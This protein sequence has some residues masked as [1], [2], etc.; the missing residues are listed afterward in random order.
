MRYLVHHGIKGQKWGVRRYR[1]EDGTLTEEGRKRYS[2][3]YR[4]RATN[5][6][7]DD[8][9]QIVST[10]SNKER[11]FLNMDGPEYLTS[12]E[13]EFVVKR[14]I[15]RE[16]DKPVA[17]L[18]LIRNDN[19]DLE[20]AL[21]TDKNHR[22]SGHASELTKKAMQWSDK[23][24]RIIW[25]THNNNTASSNIATK[26]GFAQVETGTRNTY[27]KVKKPKDFIDS[28]GGS[29][30]GKD[31]V[32]VSG[33]VSYDK[34]L[35]GMIRKEIGKAIKSNSKI[36]IGDAPGADTIV[37]EYL[38][39]KGY[40]NVEVYTTDKK[41]RSNVGNWKVKTIAS[42]GFETEREVRRQKD[43][44]MTNDCTKAIAIS[45]DDDKESSAMSLN[46]E[47]IQQQGKNV[48][49]YD[50]KKDRLTEPFRD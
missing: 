18:D 2:S 35:S 19:N 27:V 38:A 3:A 32:F 7:K 16:G 48:Q 20:V 8:V 24:S 26:S 30:S 22:G 37:Q 9:D 39:K 29:Y 23:W 44:A 50:F 47:R 14:F 40:K 5:R 42:E 4:A 34:P 46:V 41:V 17:F 10:L 36:I 45:F 13:G 21:A 43:I 12:E 25:E 15:K 11:R 28:K 49:F 31:T 6:T 33:K 1:N